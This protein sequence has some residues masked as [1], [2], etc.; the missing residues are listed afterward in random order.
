MKTTEI[1]GYMSTKDL[2]QH[3]RRS[4]RTLYRWVKQGKLPP[5][6]IRQ[7]G[8]LALWKIED[9]EKNDQAISQCS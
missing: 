2:M 5:P 6:A 3:Y 1:K 7:Q 9:I 8:A 4:A